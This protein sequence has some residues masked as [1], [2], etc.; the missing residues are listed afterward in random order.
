MRR[1]ERTARPHFG[2]GKA[3]AA[4]PLSVS[5]FTPQRASLLSPPASVLRSPLRPSV[6]APVPAA[7]LGHRSERKRRRRG[8]GDWRGESG[9]GG[10]KRERRNSRFPLMKEGRRRH[11]R[12]SRS[13]LGLPS[14][15]K[16]LLT[17]S[18]NLNIYPRPRDH[19]WTD[20]SMFTP[21]T[22]N[23]QVEWNALVAAA[24]PADL[25]RRRRRRRLPSARF[26]NAKQAQR[27]LGRRPRPSSS[28]FA[29]G[30]DISQG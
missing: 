9:R 18:P 8:G 28:A 6:R 21:P 17:L 19:C 30:R 29:V 2:H 7:S 11:G 14:V 5:V 27:K 16:E 15:V 20:L 26:R 24:A 22:F 23:S 13:T 1:S 10:R 12:T 3:A 4:A 25:S